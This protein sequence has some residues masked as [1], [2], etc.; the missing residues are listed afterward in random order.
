MTILITGY[1]GLVGSAL[2]RHLLRLSPAVPLILA[3]RNP[4]PADPEDAHAPAV[5]RL[6][7]LDPSTFSSAFEGVDRLFLLRPP[8]ISD[9]ETVFAPL[10]EAARKAGIEELMFLSVQ[11]AERSSI[12]PH[13]RIEVLVRSL[14]FRYVFLRPGYF[15]QN[16]QGDLWQELVQRKRISLP[17]AGA[18]FSWIDV[19]DIAEAAAHVL[20]DPEWD[21]ARVYTL[22][23]PELLSFA[24]VIGRMNATLRLNL[25]YRPVG[26]LRFY[27]LSRRLG[28]SHGLSLV[29]L[30]LHFLP[31]LQ[32]DPPRF[33]DL[34]RLLG[35]PA[36]RLEDY[37][38]REKEAFRVLAP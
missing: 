11:G 14:G 5:R 31:R 28:R 34:E 38:I 6:D 1:K 12:I 33:A 15:M 32:D 18:R 21:E 37:W 13:Q 25:R 4:S 29:M 35:R 3:D 7:M 30:L 36:H 8:Q 20:L 10:L 19:E 22:T 27:F 9:V 23:G 16:L 17:A 26:P 2:L 24:A